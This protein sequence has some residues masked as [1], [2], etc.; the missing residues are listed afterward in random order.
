VAQLRREHPPAKLLPVL[1][2][3][4]GLIDVV[5]IQQALEAVG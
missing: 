4:H 3:C 1:Y 5:T 2:G